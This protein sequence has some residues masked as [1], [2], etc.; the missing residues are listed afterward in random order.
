MRTILCETEAV[1]NSRPI[2]YMSEDSTEL[3]ALSPSMFLKDLQ[4]YGT[5]DL[6]SI[7]SAK[8]N[9]RQ[10]KRLQIKSELRERFRSEYISQLIQRNGPKATRPI[11]MGELVMLINDKQK[12]ALWPLAKVIELCPSSDGEIRVAK[13]RTVKG[14]LERPVK[15][16]IPLE[17]RKGEEVPIFGLSNRQLEEI[18]ALEKSETKKQPKSKGPKKDKEKAKKQ[19]VDKITTVK[20]TKSG[21]MVKP[22]QRFGLVD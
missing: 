17:I 22:V 13:V 2:T 6:D 4:E 1:I 20:H 14:E 15:K 16:L 12:R 19:T 21:R 11:E 8:L 9:E 5:P 10:Q 18:A 7:N 3:Q